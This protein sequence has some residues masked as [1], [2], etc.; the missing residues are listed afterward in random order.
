MSSEWD[1]LEDEL[2]EDHARL[3]RD[4]I[5]RSYAYAESMTEIQNRIDE[6]F[7]PDYERSPSAEAELGAIKYIAKRAVYDNTAW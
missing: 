2:T 5:A 6:F 3:V 4:E 7:D 1:W